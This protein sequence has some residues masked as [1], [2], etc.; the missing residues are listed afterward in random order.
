MQFVGILHFQPSDRRLRRAP[1]PPSD[2]AAARQTVSNGINTWRT[3]PHGDTLGP[4]PGFRSSDIRTP[5]WLVIG[6]DRECRLSMTG[7]SKVGLVQ[8]GGPAR[9]DVS[10]LSRAMWPNHRNISWH[11]FWTQLAVH[12]PIYAR[13]C[14]NIAERLLLQK[15]KRIRFLTHCRKKGQRFGTYDLV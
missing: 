9:E 10:A 4:P 7:E 11:W 3:L 1:S 6:G 8:L 14:A 13:D 5:W 12:W 15:P 2:P